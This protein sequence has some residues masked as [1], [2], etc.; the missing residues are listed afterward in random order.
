MEEVKL[1][2]EYVEELIRS[3]MQKSES[4]KSIKVVDELE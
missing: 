4:T 2:E 1:A 3:M